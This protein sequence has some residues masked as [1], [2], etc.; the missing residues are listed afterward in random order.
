MVGTAFSASNAQLKVYSNPAGTQ[1]H[2][3][4]KQAQKGDRQGRRALRL[5]GEDGSD[6]GAEVCA[7]LGRALQLSVQQP[8]QLLRLQHL[9]SRLNIKI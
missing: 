4:E 9:H 8:L 6:G 2:A 3:H 5:A 1:A 7:V